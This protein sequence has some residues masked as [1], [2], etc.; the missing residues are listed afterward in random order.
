M[1]KKRRRPLHADRF[2]TYFGKD[3]CYVAEEL[4]AAARQDQ[5]GARK[6]LVTFL[7]RGL[8]R[9]ATYEAQRLLA[10]RPWLHEDCAGEAVCKLL[11]KLPAK[12]A[13]YDPQYRA[14]SAGDWSF[15]QYLD[16]ALQHEIR[17]AAKNEIRDCAEGNARLDPQAGVAYVSEDTGN[18]TATYYPN[19]R[20]EPFFVRETVEVDENVL[21]WVA[22]AGDRF[23]GMDD[24]LPTYTKSRR[25]DRIVAE[26]RPL[27]VSEQT[28]K[29]L[30][31]VLGSPLPK[32][33]L[34]DEMQSAVLEAQASSGTERL[35]LDQRWSAAGCSPR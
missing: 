20:V 31:H 7:G 9:L 27:G 35:Q 3:A 22:A 13:S 23:A 10:G 16:G 8:N 29:E 28:E 14:K 24:T 32:A 1:A 17:T 6:R 18:L 34:L 4:H 11:E 33:E 5:P 19:R 25:L 26:L 30:R 12:I 21:R 2:N 15:L